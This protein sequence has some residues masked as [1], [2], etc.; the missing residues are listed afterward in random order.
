MRLSRFPLGLGL[1]LGLLTA[2]PS[3][4]AEEES[5]MER[6]EI[7]AEASD[8]YVHLRPAPGTLLSG[9]SH[10]H[11][12]VAR[13][14]SGR[15]E[16]DPNRPEACWVEV[17]VPVAGLDVDPPA[18]REEMAF[19]KDLSDGDRKKVDRNMRAKGQLWAEEHPSIRFRGT[20]CEVLE[21]GVLQLE[22]SLTIRGVSNSLSLPIRVD[23]DDDGLRARV[24]F[25]QTHRAYG[26][27][28]Y[29]AL[30][31]SL[32]NDETISFHVDLRA[33]RVKAPADPE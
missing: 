17:D 9:L 29:S 10:E 26:F 20:R 1:G 23:R 8:V 25:D 21:D 3:A 19:D 32:K 18:K 16:W 15:V 27:E 31:G 5:T 2:I 28:P 11:V 7:D 4:S 6:Y 24:E 30:L 33:R 12:I 14:I 22:G 13:Q